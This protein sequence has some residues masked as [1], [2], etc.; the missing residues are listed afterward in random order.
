MTPENNSFVRA[1]SAPAPA[2]VAPSNLRVLA[3]DAFGTTVDCDM[4]GSPITDC[5]VLLI[6]AYGPAVIRLVNMALDRHSLPLSRAELVALAP[7]A[8]AQAED[9]DFGGNVMTDYSIVLENS[10]GYGQVT[11]QLVNLALAQRALEASVAA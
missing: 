1:N 8:F 2:R 6:G 4:R 7:E 11:L 9:R 5:D 10:Y 3:N